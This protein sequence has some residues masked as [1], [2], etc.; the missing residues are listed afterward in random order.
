MDS[1]AKPV[2]YKLLSYQDGVRARAGLLVA[3]QVYDLARETGDA[4][5]ATVLEMLDGWQHAEA[6]LGE[7]AA[8]ASNGASRS[9][10]IPLA[11]TRLLAPVLYPGAIYGAGANY[12]DHIREMER[13]QNMPEGPTMK[14]MGDTPWHFVKAARSSITGPGA[15]VKLPP[16]S[17]AVDWEVELVAV[18]GRTASNV[19]VADALGYVAGYTIANDLSARDVMLRQNNPPSSPFRFDWVAH[20]SFDGSCPLG[21]WIAPTCDIPDPQN[22]GLKLW[23]EGEPMQDS[24]TSKMVFSVAEQIAA[25]SSRVTLHPGDLILT[26][27]PAGVGMPRKVFLKPGQ[28]VKLWIEKIGEFEHQLA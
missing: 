8:R 16:Y 21:P 7:V 14:E 4:G 28:T 6:V 25:L 3:G 23:V 12:I 20:K 13:A 2:S 18:I 17:K 1:D 19:S 26:G 10:G 24:S 22:L 15:I 9:P 11:A 27:T 5:F